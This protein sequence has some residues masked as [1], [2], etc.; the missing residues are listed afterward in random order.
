MI[1]DKQID[2]LTGFLLVTSI[3]CYVTSNPLRQINGELELV[4]KEVTVT[5]FKKI[6]V[7]KRRE[8]DSLE[9]ETEVLSTWLWRS[10]L[11]LHSGKHDLE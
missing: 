5:C 9:Y 2:I 3:D 4:W 7:K 8:T 1:P 6:S 11:C 10:A